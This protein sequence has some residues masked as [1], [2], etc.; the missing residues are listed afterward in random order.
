MKKLITLLLALVLCFV[1]CACGEDAEKLDLYDKY[2]KL[3][4]YMEDEKYDKAVAWI[5]KKAEK[6]ENNADDG[7]ALTPDDDPRIDEYDRL[8]RELENL[9]EALTENWTYSY[10]YLPEGS[11]EYVWL[12]GSEAYLQLREELLAMDGYKDTEDLVERFT[13]L[14]DMLVKT[15]TSYTDALGNVNENFP[16]P[17]VYGVDG[18][19]VKGYA[20]EEFL[21][22]AGEWAIYNYEYDDSGRV[23]SLKELWDDAIESLL[24]ITYNS[25]G[26]VAATEYKDSNGNFRNDTYVYEGGR[27]IQQLYSNNYDEQ[28]IITYTY[29]EAGQLIKTEDQEMND[30]SWQY[31]DTVAYTYD[32]KG[33]VA[34]KR[35]SEFYFYD[36]ELQSENYVHEWTYT[37]DG[38]KLVTA[39]DTHLGSFNELGEQTDSDLEFPKT[40]TYTYGTYCVYTPAN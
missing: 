2:D 8:C 33:N 3:I 39:L 38:G 10:N 24:N 18:R 12:E 15:T 11:D 19:I 22:Q 17:N 32:A 13:V 31:I 28:H 4:D 1:L 35:V 20:P 7:P 23:V 5:I 26:T 6:K 27:L 21:P 16:T 36:G 34:S 37:Y 30:S 29:D 14:E 40:H 9:D 25:D